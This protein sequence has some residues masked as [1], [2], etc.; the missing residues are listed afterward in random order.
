[1]EKGARLESCVRG[2]RQGSLRRQTG[3]HTPE[4]AVLIDHRQ[5]PSFDDRLQL[6]VDAQL[7]AEAAD[8]RAYGGATDPQRGGN[9]PARGALSHHAEYLLFTRRQALRLCIHLP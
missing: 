6:G 2:S 4:E 9:V 7:A 5:L 1:M 8:V 3:P